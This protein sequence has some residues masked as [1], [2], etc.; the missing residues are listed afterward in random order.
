MSGL[1]PSSVYLGKS[2]YKRQQCINFEITI[3]NKGEFR[4]NSKTLHAKRGT[5]LKS[6]G[7]RIN[8]ARKEKGMTQEELAALLNVSRPTIS[9]WE[10]GR[11]LPDVEMLNSLSKV[12]D[13]NFFTGEQTPVLAEEAEFAAQ[14]PI[15]AEEAQYQSHEPKAC[16]ASKKKL[17]IGLAALVL[18][19]IGVCLFFFLR[20]EPKSV[21]AE[22]PEQTAET[23]LM[24]YYARK[25]NEA[26]PVEGQAYLT[27]EPRENPV[28]PSRIPESER[29]MWMYEFV[30]RA[31]NN[32][33]FT[34]KEI[35]VIEITEPPFVPITTTLTPQTAY[36]SSA[37]ITQKTPEF[38]NGGMPVQA[39]QG[40]AMTVAGT[41]ANGNEL[42]FYGLAE[43][44]TNDDE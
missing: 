36:W 29:P 28:R 37:T 17:F 7:E 24:A 6:I 20:D 44:R 39:I 21:P 26:A 42:T 34:V 41:D 3:E 30:V 4:Y 16:S 5:S 32:I 23:D 13:A 33:A 38:L 15:Q 22:N 1:S 31:K 19:V 2:A 43:F 12:L 9:H 11:I 10:N 40:V 18:V 27:I 35:T 8:A 14:T 25:V